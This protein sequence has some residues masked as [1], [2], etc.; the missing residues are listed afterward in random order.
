MA[1]FLDQLRPH[2]A[3][4]MPSANL[5]GM[6]PFFWPNAKLDK[7][8][9]DL[10]ANGVFS[11]IIIAGGSNFVIE[12][13]KADHQNFKFHLEIRVPELYFESNYVIQSRMF[14]MFVKGDGWTKATLGKMI[15]LTCKR[16]H[17]KYLTRIIL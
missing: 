5:Q 12:D 4:G 16:E 17:S 2:L 11:N 10:M 13:I 14:G 1:K 15:K 9:S 8:D 6:D 7:N 3:K